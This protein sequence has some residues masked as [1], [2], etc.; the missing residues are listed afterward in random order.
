MYLD[1]R[2]HACSAARTTTGHSAGDDDIPIVIAI[3]V[4]L[5]Y[6]GFCREL[7][8]GRVET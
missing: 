4:D 6:L 1:K 5:V 3:G 8:F 7:K 2:T